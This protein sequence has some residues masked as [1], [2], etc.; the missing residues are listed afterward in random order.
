MTNNVEF[1]K[2]LYRSKI[3]DL[4]NIKHNKREHNIYYYDKP[5]R[6]I[7]CENKVLDMDDIMVKTKNFEILILL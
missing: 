4:S 2:R 5:Y 6:I 3:K 1:I 7:R